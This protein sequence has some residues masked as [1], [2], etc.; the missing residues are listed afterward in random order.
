MPLRAGRASGRGAFQLIV[1]E[2]PDG[3]VMLT[4]ADT[5]SGERHSLTLK[6]STAYQGHAILFEKP[7]RRE[8]LAKTL[9]LVIG[10]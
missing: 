1:A 2:M 3:S 4:H 8:E 6:P 9:R 7:F 5:I 10:R